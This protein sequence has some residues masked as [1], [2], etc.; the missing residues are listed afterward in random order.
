TG[1]YHVDL[2]VVPFDTYRVDVDGVAVAVLTLRPGMPHGDFIVQAGNC[3]LA[4][5]FVTDAATGAPLAGADVVVSGRRA[6]TS[7][8]GWY[9]IEFGCNLPIGGN[10]TFI[11]FTREGY[12]SKAMSYGRGVLGVRR[13]DA[14][15]ARQ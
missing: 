1:G 6:T 3:S 14:T 2:P 12:T 13:F 11:H 4:Y 15:L 8:R 5:G 7:S 10:T 9:L